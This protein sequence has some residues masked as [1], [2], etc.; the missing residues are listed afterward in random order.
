[1]HTDYG[2]PAIHAQQG[3]TDNA[4]LILRIMCGEKR[5]KKRGENQ[6]MEVWVILTIMCGDKKAKKKLLEVWTINLHTRDHEALKSSPLNH[7]A[8]M[9]TP[10]GLLKSILVA[11]A[12]NSTIVVVAI[13]LLAAIS[14][15]LLSMKV[16]SMAH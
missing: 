9:R 6:V 8:M 10:N 5:G 14:Q 12:L 7:C 3:Y 16:S 11:K 15:E 2:N 13:E 1:M 4:S